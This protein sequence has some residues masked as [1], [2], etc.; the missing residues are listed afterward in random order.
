MDQARSRPIP[1][2]RVLS[3]VRQSARLS[4]TRP[5][6]TS[7]TR[8]AWKAAITSQM[9]LPYDTSP[10][11]PAYRLFARTATTISMSSLQTAS[12]ITAVRLGLIIVNLRSASLPPPFG[13]TGAGRAPPA[14]V[15]GL[16]EEW[17]EGKKGRRGGMKDGRK[18]GWCVVKCTW[19]RLSSS[20]DGTQTAPCASTTTTL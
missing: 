19:A 15:T 7:T 8:H 10:G 18:A 12:I 16:S 6:M 11:C 4:R 13:R 3:I 5:S 1:L 9:S 14:C 2:S 20:S 17:D